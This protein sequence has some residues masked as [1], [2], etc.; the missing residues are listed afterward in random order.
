MSQP[1]FTVQ[2]S[3]FLWSV[4]DIMLHKHVRRLVVV[5]PTGEIAGLVN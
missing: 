5:Q 1:L 2:L 4:L 3:D